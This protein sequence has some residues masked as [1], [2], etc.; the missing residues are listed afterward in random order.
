MPGACF[1]QHENQSYPPSLSDFG[2]LHFGKKSDLLECLKIEENV[3]TVK[4]QAV[5]IDGAA[6]IHKL[7]PDHSLHRKFEDYALKLF[8]PYIEHMLEQDNCTRV[9][10]V[11]DKY[12]PD[13]LKGSMR[14]KRG[15]G[16]RRRVEP[17][18]SI[19]PNWENF[20]RE[21]KNKEELFRYLATTVVKGKVPHGKDI[22]S[23][24]SDSVISFT[25]RD[26]PSLVPCTQEEAD[27]RLLLHVADCVVDGSR[28]ILIKTV[29]NDVAVLA[30]SHYQQLN[31]Q[32]LWVEIA[33]GK[34]KHLIGAHTLV[35]RL[36][37]DK[38]RALIGFHAFTGSDCTSA[39]VGR[40][41]KTAWTLSRPV[42]STGL[43]SAM[44][45][46]D[47][48]VVLMYDR[49]S[50]ETEVTVTRKVLFAKK[51]RAMN[52]IPPTR[53][54]LMQHTRLASSGGKV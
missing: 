6:L 28:E 47:R 50:N 52:A 11:W 41:K 24:Y 15:S 51:G 45:Q 12:L 36:G 17:H 9:D 40:S 10:V 32:E 4:P 37:E 48:F 33:A 26:R 29:D 23:T 54:A 31:I 34:Q 25:V 1:F 22:V 2:D 3:P 16:T 20:L 8:L 39:C 44:Q 13:S 21:E 19:P 53:E 35:E 5:I 43:D 14:I 18:N 49:T 46:L 42:T 38:A 7:R 30:I 27:G